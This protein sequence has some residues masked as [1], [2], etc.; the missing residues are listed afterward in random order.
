MSESTAG[1]R[2]GW[3]VRGER[4]EGR[5]EA[6]GLGYHWKPVMAGPDVGSETG[7]ASVKFQGSLRPASRLSPSLASYCRAFQNL[8]EQLVRGGIEGKF[9][10]RRAHV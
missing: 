4:G 10:D 6:T 2:A 9:P 7:G 3:G 1:E 5:L 8:R